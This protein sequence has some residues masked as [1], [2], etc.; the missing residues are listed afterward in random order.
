MKLCGDYLDI[1]EN[2]RIFVTNASWEILNRTFFSRISKHNG[3]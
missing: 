1:H 2:E 3:G